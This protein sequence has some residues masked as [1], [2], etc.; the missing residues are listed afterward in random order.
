MM[1]LTHNQ[2]IVFDNS[3]FFL[4]FAAYFLINNYYNRVNKS[5]RALCLKMAKVC[6]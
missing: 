1:I 2:K 6:F 5:G 4:P 3:H